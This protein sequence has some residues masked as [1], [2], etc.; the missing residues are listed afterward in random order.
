MEESRLSKTRKSS[1]EKKFQTEMKLKNTKRSDL[2]L[3]LA[4][5]DLKLK[6]S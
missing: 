3:N 5:I 4:N 2:N 1:E 6:N